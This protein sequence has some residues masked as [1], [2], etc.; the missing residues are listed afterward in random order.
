M[1]KFTKYN[2]CIC[3]YFNLK[4]KLVQLLSVKRL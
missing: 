2:K 1:D 3:V 4:V